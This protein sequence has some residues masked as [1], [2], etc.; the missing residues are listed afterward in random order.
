MNCPACGH[1]N[2][3]DARFCGECAAPLAT[4]LACPSCGR[5]NPPTQ[6]FCDGCAQPLAP[7]TPEREPRDY[8]PKHLADKILQSKSALEGE[9]KQVTVLFADVRGSLELTAQVDPEEWH[10]ILDR[11]FQILADAVHR[12]EG[13]VNQYTGDGDHGALRGAHRPRGPRAAGLLGGAAPAGRA[14]ALRRRAAGRAGAELLRAHGDQL[15]R[16]GGREDRRRPAHG[17]HRA[18]SDGGAWP[19][20]WRSWRNRGA[21]AT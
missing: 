6:K 9:R 17:L 15:R 5:S 1:A 4:E 10:R 14:A 16:G 20:G 12:F 21:G 8:T 11:F 13:T 7:A 18:G 19:R 3:D 2:R